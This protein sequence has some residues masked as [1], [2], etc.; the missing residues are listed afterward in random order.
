MLGVHNIYMYA[1][2]ED[3]KF[4]EPVSNPGF[5]CEHHNNEIG[6]NYNQEHAPVAN[7][8]GWKSGTWH[9]NLSPTHIFFILDASIFT[10]YV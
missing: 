4:T 7:Q 10:C 5:W 6:F 3:S 9:T 8:V 1:R 2:K